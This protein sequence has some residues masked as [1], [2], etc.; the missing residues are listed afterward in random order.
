MCIRAGHWGALLLA[1]WLS[2]C[3][4]AAPTPGPVWLPLVVKNSAVATAALISPASPSIGAPSSIPAT[5]PRTLPTP[6][7]NPPPT[8]AIPPSPTPCARPGLVVSALSPSQIQGPW[9]NYRIYLPPC[10]AGQQLYP[11]LYLLH[12]NTRADEEWDEIGVD[13]AADALIQAGRIPPLLIVMPDGRTLSDITSGG[14]D[15]YEDSLMHEFIPFIE[16]TYCAAP[17]GAWRALGGLSRGGYWA[18]EIAFRQ[19]QEFSSVGGHAAALL[20][21]AAW[22]AIDPEVTAFSHSLGGLR[23]YFD[24]GAQDWMQYTAQALHENML[25]ATIAHEWLIHPDGQH[26][27]PYWTDHVAEYL[28]WYAQGWPAEVW[29]PPPCF[30]SQP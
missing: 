12:G 21:V 23:I 25:A 15:S 8:L 29:S 4:S 26:Q 11:T 1:V 16:Q 24:Y 10:F 28:F 2:G 30:L 7:P 17:T 18:L 3:V 9:R 20:D 5:T 19:P 22:P 27:D 14:P 13:E 6:S